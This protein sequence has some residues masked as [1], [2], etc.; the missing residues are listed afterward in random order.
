MRSRLFP[1]AAVFVLALAGASAAAAD[2]ASESGTPRLSNMSAGE[3]LAYHDKLDQE[4]KTR[5]YE[6]ITS[7]QIDDIGLEQSKIRALIGTHATLD[8]LSNQDQVSVFNA[9]ERV[10]AIVEGAEDD[11]VVCKRQKVVGSHRP[12]SVCQTVGE[13]KRTRQRIGTDEIVRQARCTGANCTG[14]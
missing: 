13:M 2:N 4:L 11:R 7:S 12:V 1:I 9:H 10:V 8:E 6:H 14:G 3:F 5:R